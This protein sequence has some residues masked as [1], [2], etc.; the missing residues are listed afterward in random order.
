M[1]VPIRYFSFQCILLIHVSLMC[2]CFH[3]IPIVP[4]VHPLGI[5]T[6]LWMVDVLERLGID[7]YFKKEIQT[8]LDKIY[9]SWL[10][11]EEEI[12]LD[13]AT[14]AMAFRVLRFNRYDVSSALQF[15]AMKIS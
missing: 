7:Q 9:E 6:R 12:F 13:I 14:C 15:L 1:Q 10:N 8:V 2:S 5:Y 3:V 4:T 11:R